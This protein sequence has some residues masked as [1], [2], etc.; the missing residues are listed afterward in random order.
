M[1]NGV[2]RTARYLGSQGCVTLP[3]G[4]DSVS[5]KPVRVKSTLPD[6]ATQ[7][8][9]MGDVLPTDPLPGG[10]RRGAR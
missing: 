1:P 2:T 3:V 8:W 5:F 6:P 7:P 10:D 4:Q 9:P